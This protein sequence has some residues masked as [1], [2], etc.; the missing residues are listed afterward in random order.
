MKHLLLFFF[1]FS[2]I[3]LGAQPGTPDP[4]FNTGSPINSLSDIALQSDGKIVVVGH[5]VRHRDIATHITRL[6]TDGSVDTLFNPEEGTDR[7]IYEVAVQ[8]DGKILIGGF[9]TSFNGTSRRAIARLHSDGS[10]DTSFDPGTGVAENYSVQD[11]V[12]QPDGKILIGGGFSVFNGV[13]IRGIARL[14]ADGS[15]DTSFNPGTGVLGFGVYTMAL[16][17]DGKIV[18]GGNINRYNGVSQNNILRLNADGS[19][20]TSFDPGTGAQGVRRVDVVYL[21]PDGKILIGGAFDTYNAIARSA[22]ARLNTDGS[23]DSSFD[24]GEGAD[25]ET[26]FGVGGVYTIVTL[27]S[28]NIVIGGDFE[29]YNG[30][31]RGG[32]AWLNTDGSLNTSVDIR[33]ANEGYRA[34][35]NNILLQPDGNLLVG[36]SFSLFNDLTKYNVVRIQGE[37]TS[38]IKHHTVASLR[39][40]PNPSSGLFHL[41]NFSPTN[42][43]YSVTDMSGREVR[44]GK[45]VS[46]ATL[47]DLSPLS[48]GIY[49][50]HTKDGTLKVVKN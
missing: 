29:A 33:P 31:P 36:G 20:D 4:L 37:G 21:Q 35:I 49:F 7:A 30:I 27:P 9:F 41:E 16:Q 32:M 28:G 6:N 5:S 14:N 43:P 34:T 48:A 2:F 12:V 47:L 44:S 15:L 23:L 11:I 25:I 38:G 19:I 3:S 18:I 50:L 39:V 42:E 1:T 24:P 13:N 46:P 17:P 10:L 22:I 40:Y 26:N 45:I 8:E